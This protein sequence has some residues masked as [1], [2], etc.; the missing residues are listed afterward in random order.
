MPVFITWKNEWTHRLS[1][2]SQRPREQVQVQE[3]SLFQILWN[4]WLVSWLRYFLGLIICDIWYLGMFDN[5][6]DFLSF[7]LDLNWFNVSYLL[8]SLLSF[9]Y[10]LSLLFWNSEL[11]IRNIYIAVI[12]LLQSKLILWNNFLSCHTKLG[13]KCNVQVTNVLRKTG[14]MFSLLCYK[15]IK[16]LQ[17]YFGR[18]YLVSNLNQG[19]ITNGFYTN[20]IE[21]AQCHT[22]HVY[23]QP[24][25]ISSICM[26]TV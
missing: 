7:S 10:I 15:A 9:L 4:L 25:I 23:W 8:F 11:M 13:I 17:A 1:A 22:W 12:H 24:N 26:K 2:K 19:Q 21:Y 6:N 16:S 14:N 18:L 20:N 3:A 5:V